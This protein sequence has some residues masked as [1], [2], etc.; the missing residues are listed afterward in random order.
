MRK[1]Y[2]DYEDFVRLHQIQLSIYNDK[3]IKLIKYKTM[4]IYR[5]FITMLYKLTLNIRIYSK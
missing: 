5:N 1:K 4:T 2:K 3:F